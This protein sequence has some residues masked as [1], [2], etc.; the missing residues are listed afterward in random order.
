MSEDLIDYIRR[1][2]EDEINHEMHEKAKLRVPDDVASI[3]RSVSVIQGTVDEAAGTAERQRVEIIQRLD[4]L[5]FI[6]KTHSE[7]VRHRL[8]DVLWLLVFILA[9]VSYA[10]FR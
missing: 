9:V 1:G 6:A 4:N 5:Q 10:V 7:L 2:H 8:R 3:E